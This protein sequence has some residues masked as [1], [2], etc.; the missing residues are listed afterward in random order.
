MGNRSLYL[1]VDGTGNFSAYII[2]TDPKGRNVRDAPEGTVIVVLH[3]RPENPG[4]ITVKVTGHKKGSPEVIF[5]DDEV[6]LLGGEGQWA[7]VEYAVPGGVETKGWR[8]PVKRC[9]T[10]YSTCP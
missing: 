8:D 6:P 3:L 10:L 5:R 1:P 9:A 7:L 2:D 4:I